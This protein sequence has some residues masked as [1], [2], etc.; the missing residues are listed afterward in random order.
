[1]FS[2]YLEYLKMKIRKLLEEDITALAQIR[3]LEWGTEEYWI[4]RIEGYLAKVKNPQGAKS[5]RTILVLE[6]ENKVVGF[7]AGHATSRYDCQGELQWINVLHE[8]QGQSLAS[9]LLKELA[10][11]FVENNILSVCVNVEPDNA[12][13]IAFYTKNQAQSINEHWMKWDDISVLL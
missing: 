4:N 3:S 13:A 7:I 10:K 8:F 12:T 11:W 9:Y 5:E 1:M 6:V 2:K